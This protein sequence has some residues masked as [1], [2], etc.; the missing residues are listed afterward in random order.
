MSRFEVSAVWLVDSPKA[1]RGPD[2]LVGVWPKG[3]RLSRYDG[4]VLTVVAD[5]RAKT[6]EDARALVAGRVVLAWEAVAG[7]VVG[8]PDRCR[9]VRRE[10]RDRVSAGAGTVFSGERG[11]ALRRE[12]GQ[13]RPAG[14][15]WPDR[16]HLPGTGPGGRQDRDD[17]GPDDGGLAGVREP[18]RPRPGPGSAGA[19]APLPTAG[20][21]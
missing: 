6:P 4:T 12:A 8:A 17:D 3:L 9:V 10:R 11:H 14:R 18:R 2:V 7:E 5:V 13:D 15:P 20:V 1:P 21:G 16:E 19:E